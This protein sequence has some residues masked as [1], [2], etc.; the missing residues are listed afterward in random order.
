MNRRR[1]PFECLSTPAN[2]NSGLAAAAGSPAPEMTTEEVWKSTPVITAHLASIIVG[3]WVAGLYVTPQILAAET[4]SD[5][6]L[7]KDE[8]AENWT[9]ALSVATFT[10]HSTNLKIPKPPTPNQGEDR[11]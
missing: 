8:I 4:G 1:N 3:S 9:V 10:A 5:D 11:E 7:T 6:D 2:E